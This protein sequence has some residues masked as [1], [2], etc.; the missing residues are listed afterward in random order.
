MPIVVPDVAERALLEMLV[1]TASPPDFEMALYSNDYTPVETSVAA[2]FTLHA[3]AGLSIIKALARASWGTAA[4]ATG[5]T[6]IAYPQQSWQNTSGA[7]Q[8]VYGYI[9]RKSGAGDLL[10]AERFTTA[11]IVL[12]NTDYIFITPRLELG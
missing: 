11:P 1:K 9:V 5:V 12:A 4:T 3:A 10:W 8:N 6:S 7:N 2:D